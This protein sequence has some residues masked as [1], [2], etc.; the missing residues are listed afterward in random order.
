MRRS[1]LCLGSKPRRN[2]GRSGNKLDTA[3]GIEL[4]LPGETIQLTGFKVATL[5]DWAFHF[6]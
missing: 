2:R 5:G 6:A 1:P 4:R 3:A